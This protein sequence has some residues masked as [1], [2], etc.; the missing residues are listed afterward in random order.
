MPHHFPTSYLYSKWDG[1]ED[2]SLNPDDVFDA[3]SEDLLRDGN[4]SHALRRA[5]HWGMR[6]PDGS[7]TDG[8]RDLA[9]RLRKQ[10]QEMLDKFDFDSALGDIAER[11]QDIVDR[12]RSTLDARL[13][14]ESPDAESGDQAGP[15]QYLQNKREKLDAIPDNVGSRLTE[16]QN[17]DF[18]DRHAGEDFEKL[19]DELRQQIT[20]SLFNNLMGA[21]QNPQS[22][23]GGDLKDFLHDLN[24]AFDQQAA[25]Q[26]VDMDK[27]NNKW[28]HMFGG[29]A[30]S[31]DEIAER[32]RS[33]MA[34]AQAL[35]GMLSP[36]QRAD[37]RAAME[38]A[39]RDAGIED[40]LAQLQQNLGPIPQSNMDQ[41]GGPGQEQLELNMAMNVME[42]ANQM[43]E[44][45]TL[46]RATSDPD[47]L[48][49]IPSEMLEQVLNEQ[50]RQWID[51]WTRIKDQLI[52]QGWA[53]E[54]RKGLEL[55]PRAIRKIGE[56]ALS[57]I[58]SSLKDLGP[59]EHDIRDKGT[60]GE[61]AEI[62]APWKFGDPFLLDLPR[63]VMNGVTRRGPGTPVRLRQDDFEVIERESKTSTATALLIDMSRSM[64]Y[65]GS[66]DAAKR[67]ALALDTL[68]RG[69][70]P[71]D[72][73]ELIGFSSVAHSLKM[74]DLPSLEWNEYTYG[75]NLQHALELARE[76]LRPERGRN[77][78]IIVIT[79]GEPT[80]HIVNGRPYFNYPPTWETF[81]ATLREVVRCTREQITIN[82]FLLE[83]SPYMSRFVEDLMRINRGRV[84]NASPNH[85]GGY[86]LKDFLRQRTAWRSG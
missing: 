4:L 79:D 53:V 14:Q 62:S 20:D 60:A 19:L 32:M 46:L 9:E 5:F 41:P 70:Y 6:Q 75:T 3:V 17:Y 7:H 24:E 37:L 50:D 10:R 71:R 74:T 39:M 84:M 52:E 21:A 85:L 40:E 57:D 8:L 44:V 67:A 2:A 76:K 30:N 16:L 55:T 13:G 56:K 34:A 64:Y 77:R 80:A 38:Q 59:G 63:T 28:S 78:Q 15:R 25:G 72:L 58:F 12:E 23:P 31:M 1:S 48:E 54:G 26:P 61:S 43:E 69:K 35:M 36:Q 27:L 73:L 18:V 51:N 66:W 65:T 11:L 47:D 81:E 22:G 42:R 82:V 29:R 68:I 49:G 83:Q 45:E 33:R 86:V